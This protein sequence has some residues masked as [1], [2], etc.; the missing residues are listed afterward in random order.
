MRGL[1]KVVLFFALIAAQ[2]TAP[3]AQ[4]TSETAAAPSA[5]FES[6]TRLLSL[7]NSVD[8][9]LAGLSSAELDELETSIN[10]LRELVVQG[11]LNETE[12]TEQKQLLDGIAPQLRAVSEAYNDAV[13]TI[14]EG[15]VEGFSDRDLQRLKTLCGG[16]LEDAVAWLADTDFDVAKAD[17]MVGKAEQCRLALID[18]YDA[19][20][21]LADRLDL[22]RAE[23]EREQV[24]LEQ[25]LANATTPEERQKI[26]GQLDENE[27]A[28]QDVE[29][30]QSKVQEAKAKVDWLEALG[31]LALVVAGAVVAFYGDPNTGVALMVTGGKIMES[32]LNPRTTQV[33]YDEVSVRQERTG[34]EADKAPD[35]TT[36]AA[37][38]S[39]LTIQ[40][41]SN[42]T[43]N[44]SV[45]NFIVVTSPDDGAW[46]VWQLD[47]KKLVVRID[48]ANVTVAPKDDK[49]PGL[50]SIASPQ[51]TK[52]AGT[53]PVVVNFV[54]V[55][56][57]GN[58][59]S[60]NIS[61]GAIGSRKYT[62]TLDTT[63]VAPA[64]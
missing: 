61:E 13:G 4:T 18:A 48:P 28:I 3:T 17:T 31:G 14:A 42:I 5:Q 20:N 62:I 47:P 26:Q 37:T 32:E 63:F 35:P 60:G 64:P 8:P 52:L 45:G 7:L 54:G 36:S 15:S 40:G 55:N 39:D 10:R 53:S 9:A 24:R 21:S 22:R 38:I 27:A 57:E 44:N 23:L 59:I 16:S 2:V 56:T 30:R 50:T 34:L 41:Y 12:A 33:P 25:E 43:V 1:A 11:K 6:L 19:L 46:L 49:V 29:E 58:N 51:A